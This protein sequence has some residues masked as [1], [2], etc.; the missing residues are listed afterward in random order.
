MMTD[1]N[2]KYLAKS[3]G[4]KLY[5]HS[6]KVAEFAVEI[7]KRILPSTSDNIKII[8]KINR[9][10]KS[11][12][13][14]KICIQEFLKTGKK[15]N[16]KFSHHEMGAAFLYK[17]LL[18][19][20]G[21]FIR[22]AVY[23]HHGINNEMNA[24]FFQT[25]LDTISSVHI[26]EMKSYFTEIIGEKIADGSKT[27]Q[28][29][30]PKYFIDDDDCTYIN[31]LNTVFRACIIS[32]DRIVS[33]LTDENLYNT[34]SVEKHVDDYLNKSE[35]MTATLNPYV[36]QKRFITQEQIVDSI[37]TTTIINAPAG[38]GKTL[39]GL[40][41]SIKSDKKLI[42][43]CPRN[44]VAYGVYDS[45]LIELEKFGINNSVELYLTGEVKKSNW[46]N[47]NGFESNIIVTNIDNYLN[48]SINNTHLEKLF[49]IMSA[50][51][52]F[53]EYHELACDK[54]L[55]T[56]FLN[57]IQTRHRF[58]K[59]KTLML[60]ATPKQLCYKWDTDT[61]T[62]TILP[63]KYM[64]YKAAH[65]KKYKINVVEEEINPI[66][67]QNNLV[68]LNSIR[69]AQL[70]FV[71][72]D[73]DLLIHSKFDA[74]EKEI[75][76]KKIFDEY[77]KNASRT[78]G[79][80]DI[81]SAP[82]IQAALE[83][84][85]LNLWESVLSP[86]DTLQRIGRIERWGDYNET[87]TL[88]FVKITSKSEVAMKRLLYTEEL[89]DLWF[90]CLKQY[91]GKELTLDEIYVIYNNFSRDNEAKIKKYI[92]NM[93]NESLK[94]L[95]TIYPNKYTSKNKTDILTAGGNKLRTS[96]FELFFIVKMHDSDEW[97]GPFSTAIFNSVDE[98]FDEDSST[99]THISKTI[100]KLKT[101]SRFD[102]KKMLTKPKLKF[103]T[104]DK[105]RKYAKT[106]NTPYLRFD[107][108]YHKVIGIFS[109]KDKSDLI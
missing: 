42:W 36:G 72:L 93:E 15:C 29:K 78:L 74:P 62:T 1:K 58:S 100:N 81:V 19:D 59:S 55:F 48:A 80:M 64:H 107:V 105:I 46:N 73:F 21:N 71:E 109:I 5:E 99:F 104:L 70:K 63:G 82:V 11:H 106:S 35:K 40:L 47:T 50:D 37:K 16:Y 67:G 26:E 2:K 12:D 8:E 45:I 85:F 33:R 83:L 75:L 101:D 88:N 28:K 20:D 98:D 90:D 18:L 92:D 51:V 89:S 31:N 91:N 49:L 39:I 76:Y 22:N 108:L 6:N 68:I 95:T 86:E 94:T 7:A 17:F 3:T 65:I 60:S 96:T 56:C 30:T 53:D 9:A 10:A 41:W 54:A 52:I 66:K 79:K 61:L 4:E 103:L 44:T 38:F 27:Q 34:K 25:V 24:D 84:S 23:W 57:I 14:G 87:P 69:E 32:A 102:Y 97:V 13:I 43:V 77:G